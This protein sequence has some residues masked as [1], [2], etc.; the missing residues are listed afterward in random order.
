MQAEMTI[1]LEEAYHGIAKIIELNGQKIR[2]KLK[3][4]TYDGLVIRLPGKA[5][6]GKGQGVICILLFMLLQIQIT[7]STE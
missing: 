5:S 1:S 7:R 3:P 2:I 6:V 4:G